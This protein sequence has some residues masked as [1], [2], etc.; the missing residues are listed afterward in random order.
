MNEE[1]PICLEPFE[2]DI[3]I[4]LLECSHQIHTSC[5]KGLTRYECPL[6]MKG[7]IWPIEIRN[8]IKQ[9]IIERKAEIIREDEEQIQESESRLR[10]LQSNIL[11]Q[12]DG[13]VMMTIING[14]HAQISPT[15]ESERN[16]ARQFLMDEG[17]PESMIVDVEFNSEFT[18]PPG[19]LFQ[20]I[21]SQTIERINQQMANSSSSDDS[22]GEVNS[23]LSDNEL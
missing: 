12:L 23:S 19:V 13:E 17:I 21:Y 1:C 5:A 15:P 4:I 9:N 22:D 14:I 7:V 3:D 2:N 6:C 8:I 11:E 20:A 18:P 16:Q 10:D